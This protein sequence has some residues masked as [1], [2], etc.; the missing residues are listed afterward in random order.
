MKRKWK[1]LRQGQ[2]QSL[3]TL[4]LCFVPLQLSFSFELIPGVNPT[5]DILSFRIDKRT[6]KEFKTNIVLFG[7]KT[8][9]IGLTFDFCF[10]KS[11]IR[12]ICLNLLYL[13]WP[14]VFQVMSTLG[15]NLTREEIDEMI[16]EA[17]MD[18][19]GRVC[20]EEFATMMS[21]KGAAWTVSF[22]LSHC[23]S[24]P[25]EYFMHRKSEEGKK[26]P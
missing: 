7:Q 1:K 24:V 23:V 9:F 5:E 2:T 16:R 10:A 15:E 4:I 21:H 19:D 6:S 11:R 12:L 22:M 8:I 25:D 26:K 3:F 13:H 17:D 14:T 18:G 20:Y